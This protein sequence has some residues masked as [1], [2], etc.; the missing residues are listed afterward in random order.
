MALVVL[1]TLYTVVLVQESKNRTRR[2]I[3]EKGPGQVPLASISSSASS[4][5]RLEG[6]CLVQSGPRPKLQLSVDSSFD[7]LRHLGQGPP[8]RLKRRL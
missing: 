4:S 2:M 7:D 8:A 1:C 6:R 5:A 3:L